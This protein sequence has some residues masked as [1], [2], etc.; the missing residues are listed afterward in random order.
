MT[1]EKGVL[2]AAPASLFENLDGGEEQMLADASPFRTKPQPIG[3]SRKGVPNKR[4]QQMR[5]LYLRSG[6]PHPLL[7]QGQMLRRGVD[8]LATDLG[9]TLVEAAELLRKIAADLAP[10]IEG[11]QPTR[12]AVEA[13]ARLPVLVVGEL[14]AARSELASAR[15]E[16]ALAIDDDLEAAVATFETNQAL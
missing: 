6:L 2:A 3:G 16:G 13:G 12:V 14:G 1:D 7:W 5:D 9:C 15:E 4:T 11:K 8:G 10:Y